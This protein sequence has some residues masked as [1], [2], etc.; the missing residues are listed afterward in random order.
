MII[1]VSLNKEEE[2]MD[3]SS[4]YESV[5]ETKGGAGMLLNT[6]LHPESSVGRQLP[7]LPGN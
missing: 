3:L 5:L 2:S 1:N 4:K 6:N 7:L